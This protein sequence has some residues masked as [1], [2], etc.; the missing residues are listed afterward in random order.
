MNFLKFL[1]VTVLLIPVALPAGSQKD[2]TYN[3]RKTRW[4]MTRKEVRIS[5][6]KRKPVLDPTEKEICYV[7]TI[8]GKTFLVAYSFVDNKLVSGAYALMEK[9]TNYNMYVED[10]EE[11]KELLIKKYGKPEDKW[12]DGNDY[13]EML[14]RNDLYKDDPDHWG[15]AIS[16]GDLVFRL[17][18]KTSDTDIMLQLAGDNFKVR[19]NVG[20]FS[21]NLENLQEK[22]KE[23]ETKNKF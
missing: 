16:M 9:H 4:G 8:S 12:F 22:A 5:E 15:L 17:C 14:W 10:Y 7:D 1:G 20:Y 19:L 21:R 18:W 6:G 3:F 13:R 2:V 11:V 23:K